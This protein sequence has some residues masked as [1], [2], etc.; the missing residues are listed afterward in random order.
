MTWWFMPNTATSGFVPRLDQEAEVQIEI[1]KG[2]LLRSCGVRN[3]V[4]EHPVP[5]LEPVAFH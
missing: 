3:L 5:V 2:G 1:A 4:A